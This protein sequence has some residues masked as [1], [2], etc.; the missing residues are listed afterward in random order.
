MFD[1]PLAIAVNRKALLRKVTELFAMLGDGDRV[2]RHLCLAVLAL[3][4][5]LE[6]AARRLIQVAAQE[7]SV[8]SP[9]P[10]AAPSTAIV[11]GSDG[12]R[13]P[14]FPMFDRRLD[15]DPKEKRVPGHGPNVRWLDDTEDAPCVADAPRADDMVSISALMKRLKALRKALEDIPA[16]AGRLARVLASGKSKWKRV[17]RPGRPPGHVAGG[18]RDVDILLADCHELA[19]M[20]LAEIEVANTS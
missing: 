9:A 8:G 19:L 11:R 18:K 12:E 15:V 13:V 4:R 6:S 16:H 3:L 17:M 10:R 20:A 2:P 14:A 7:I 5:P 1:Y